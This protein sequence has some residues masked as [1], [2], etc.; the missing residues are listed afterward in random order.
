MA[1]KRS[2]PPPAD[3]SSLDNNE[4]EHIESDADAASDADEQL[5]ESGPQN[6]DAEQ[7]E[8]DS[9]QEA[10]EE[11][12]AESEDEEA[13]S[14]EP[15]NPTE[16]SLQ[17]ELS[18]QGSDEKSGSNSDSE[19][20]KSSPVPVKPIRSK[21]MTSSSKKP[22]PEI[23]PKPDPKPLR[24]RA[25]AKRPVESGKN[26][27]GANKKGKVSNGEEKKSGINRLWSEEDEI[28]IL[29]GMIDYQ[30]AKEEDP[31]SDLEAFYEFVKDSLHVNV[32]IKQLSDKIRRL[33]K[34][35]LVNVEKGED[36]VFVKPHDDKSFELSKRIWGGGNGVDDGS[37]VKVARKKKDKE[38]GKA[39]NN[40][41]NGKNDVVMEDEVEKGVEVDDEEEDYEGLDFKGMY[42]YVS[43]AWESDVTCSKS[44]KDISIDN[45]RLF[46]MEKMRG[47]EK[48]WKDIYAKEMELY[49]KKLDLKTK[50]AKVVLDQ[51]T[52]SDP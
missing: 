36:V 14:E 27:K 9:E 29:Q 17:K 11:E 51:M 18:F 1:R 7:Q 5:H 34:K 48:E 22:D 37:K 19:S 4:N 15:I 28:G 47:M 16:Q 21:P 52:S 20:E 23:D 41:L 32:S 6:D 2:S 38:I 49:L 40:G 45:F 50:H 44:L 31:Y 30:L 25:S 8:D 42:P 46:G 12:E 43:K 39:V 13:E 10:E 24:K 35:Y 26:G 33:K 3:D